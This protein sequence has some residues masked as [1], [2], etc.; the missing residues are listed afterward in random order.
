MSK[1]DVLEIVSK[2]FGLYC[3][4][5]TIKYIPAVIGAIVIN[6]PEF[7]TNKTLYIVSTLMYPIVFLLLSIVF[8]L[9]TEWIVKILFST[10]SLENIRQSK[11]NSDK[12][13][14]EKLSFWI[15]LIGV[16]YLLSSIA[17][18]LYSLPTIFIKLKEGWFFT[19]DP[20]LPKTIILILSLI[21]IFKSERIERIIT[22]KRST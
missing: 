14:Y 12:P 5:Q 1:L 22:N 16:Y 17:I 9:K 2:S 7:I 4:V 20:F 15:T 6:Q 11:T 19:H 18:V 10:S 8:I 21:C 3:I 13:N